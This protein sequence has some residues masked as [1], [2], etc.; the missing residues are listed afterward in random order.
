MLSLNGFA[1]TLEDTIRIRRDQILILEDQIIAPNSDTIYVCEPDEKFKIRKNPY[2]SSEIFYERIKEA[3]RGNKVARRITDLFLTTPDKRSEKVAEEGKSSDVVFNE[4]EGYTIRNIRFKFVDILEGSVQDTTRSASS[5]LA[6]FANKQHLDTR[7][8]VIKSNL[9]IT[10]GENIDPDILAD[11]ERLLRRLLYIEDAKIYVTPIPNTKTADLTIAIKDRLAWGFQIG[12][13]N[14]KQ[15]NFE[16]FNR[17]V[18]GIGRYGSVTYF[19][20][21]N[22]SPEQGYALKLGGQNALKT[23]TRWE[24]NQSNYWDKK[25]VGLVAQ[26]EFVTPEIKYGGGV[27]LRSIIDST[28]IFDGQIENDR[29]YKLNYQDFWIGRSF[30]LRSNNERKNIVV[31]A[32]VFDNQFDFRPTV[33]RD[34]NNIY[35]NRVF[36]LGQVAFAKQ[37]FIKSNYVVGFGVSEDIPVGYRISGVFGRDFNEFFTQ[38]YFGLQYFWSKYFP[39]VGYILVNQQF[40]GFLQNSIESGL[41]NLSSSYFTPLINIRRY[42][43][44]SFL[45]F[46]MTNGINQDPAQSLTL[47]G[48]IRDV[49]GDN[50]TGEK[51]AY[52]RGESVLFTPWYFYGFRFAPFVYGSLSHIEDRRYKKEI[53]NYASLGLGFRIKNESLVFNTFEVRMTNFVVKPKNSTTPIISFAISTPITFDSIFRYKPT[54]LAFE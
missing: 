21:A 5:E 51:V 9:T 35:F 54:V 2:T 30:V 48:R 52:L 23:I 39:K 42:R 36:A 33:S 31:S 7:K 49:N 32:R 26:K 28:I 53:H 1:S 46:G 45:I 17:S 27:E 13:N 43:S 41:Y 16:L 10:S 22:S 34:S 14:L 18:G 44:R 8:W 19:N 37:K 12:Y 24:L 40:G 11:N 38:N 3:T 29:R 47:Q 20:N 4:Y 15:F 6:I 25:D 50:I